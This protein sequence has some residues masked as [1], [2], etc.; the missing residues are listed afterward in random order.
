MKNR[1]LLMYYTQLDNGNQEI[2]TDGL[3]FHAP[4]DTWTG[5]DK[6]GYAFAPRA[7]G[8][9]EPVPQTYKGVPCCLFPIG[10]WWYATVPLVAYQAGLPGAVFSAWVASDADLPKWAGSEAVAAFGAGVQDIPGTSTP[11]DYWGVTWLNNSTN[12]SAGIVRYGTSISGFDITSIRDWHHVAVVMEREAGWQFKR[13]SGT[14]YINGSLFGDVSY[15]FSNGAQGHVMLG[16]R[17]TRTTGQFY[18]AGV[19]LYNR[20]L[21]AQELIAL[22]QEYR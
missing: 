10:S 20:K 18:I 7:S 15:D 5:Q 12:L 22:S 1:D 16:T 8:V 21:T 9:A 13:W 17:H 4:L 11:Q 2:P 3:V 14:V 6:F 19:R